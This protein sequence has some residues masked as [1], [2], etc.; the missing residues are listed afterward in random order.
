MV[1]HDDQIPPNR[2]QN[3]PYDPWNDWSCPPVPPADDEQRRTVQAAMDARPNGD[4]SRIK[5]DLWRAG[6]EIPLSVIYGVKAGT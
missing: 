5:S 3:L 6:H 1:Y 2:H 4:P